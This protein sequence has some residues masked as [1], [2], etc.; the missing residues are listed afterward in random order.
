M[1]FVFVHAFAV[2]DKMKSSGAFG[3]YLAHAFGG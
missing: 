2:S 3:L 1:I